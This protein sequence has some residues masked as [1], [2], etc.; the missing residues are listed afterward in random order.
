VL[1]TATV[2]A[3]IGTWM[4][5]AG[6]GWLMTTLS[7]DPLVV[8]LVQ[9]ATTLPMFLFALPAGVLA[10]IV[11]RRKLLIAA[12]IAST[13][14]AATIAALLWLDLVTPSILLLFT[15]LLG[16]TAALSSPAWQA[17]VPELVPKQDLASAVAANSVGINISRAVGPALAGLSIA[18]V[19][20][21]SPFWLNA[22]S[23]LGI[24]GALVWW[25]SPLHAGYGLPA[26]RFFGAMRSGF[27][28]ARHSPH[29]RATLARA[30]AFSCSRALIGHY[31]R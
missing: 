15:F 5:S 26:E 20:I 28:Y 18:G 16:V 23:N 29:L 21:A 1:W 9:A 24:I 7:T 11:D 27:R 10:D 13:L 17:V 12:E 19:G 31:C 4:Y 22:A 30:V 6:A 14:F 3:N 8:S 25:K 2:V